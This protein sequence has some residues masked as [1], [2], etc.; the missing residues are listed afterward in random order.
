MVDEAVPNVPV[1]GRGAAG[2]E[3]LEVPLLAKVLL[4]DLMV[5]PHSEGNDHP[6]SLSERRPINNKVEATRWTLS[7]AWNK[8]ASPFAVNCW[9]IPH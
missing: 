6:V 1:D 9:P 7:S 5:L 2:N 4:P 3:A 8:I